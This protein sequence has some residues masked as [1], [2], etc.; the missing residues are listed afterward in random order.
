MPMRI[1]RRVASPAAA[2]PFIVR[3]PP[4]QAWP[5]AHPTP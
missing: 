1:L 3:S 2:R 5:L 4:V